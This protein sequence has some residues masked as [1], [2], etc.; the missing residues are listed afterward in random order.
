MKAWPHSS[1]MQWWSWIRG[2]KL[3]IKNIQGNNSHQFNSH[4]HICHFWR[5]KTLEIFHFKTF[6]AMKG[7]GALFTAW[8]Q[9]TTHQQKNMYQTQKTLGGAPFCFSFP[10]KQENFLLPDSEKVQ[11]LS[12]H[13]QYP[14]LLQKKDN[15]L[16]EK[17]LFFTLKTRQKPCTCSSSTFLEQKLLLLKKR[18]FFLE[19]KFT[20]H[21]CLSNASAWRGRKQMF[22]ITK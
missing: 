2:G 14:C 20:V 18:I 16:K 22:T 4:Q 21:I 5:K 11:N 9:Q 15:I 19:W 13:L 1:I 12:L 10:L 17:N 8:M 3:A 7:L 6:F